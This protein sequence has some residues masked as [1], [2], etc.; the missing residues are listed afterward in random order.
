MAGF[1]K[2][3]N[4]KGLGFLRMCEEIVLS[5]SSQVTS[6]TS[7]HADRAAEKL[8]AK[9]PANT[10]VMELERVIASSLWL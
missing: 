8:P 5:L 6:M 4:D 1:G 7:G 2:G 3:S 9:M 10:V